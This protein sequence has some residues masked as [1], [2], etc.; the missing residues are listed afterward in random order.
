MKN[1][2]CVRGANQRM[3]IELRRQNHHTQLKQRRFSIQWREDYG[4][5]LRFALYGIKVHL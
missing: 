3:H 1:V 4:D 2:L 5:R